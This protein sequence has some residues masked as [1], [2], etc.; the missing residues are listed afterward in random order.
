M[1]NWIVDLPFAAGIQFSGLLTLGSG[2]KYDIGGRFDLANF[3]RGGFVPPKRAFILG[4][5]WRYRNVDVRLRKDFPSIS[6]TTLGVT[7]DVFNVFNF[8]NYGG[9]NTNPS[10]ADFGKPNGVL[11]DPRRLQLGAEVNF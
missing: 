5:F 8:N 4:N 3:T 6:G 10:S 9:Y 2:T 1:G 7:L 11:S